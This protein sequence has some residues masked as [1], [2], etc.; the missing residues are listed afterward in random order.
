[1]TDFRGEVISSET[2]ARGRRIINS[3]SISE[4]HAVDFTDSD[5]FYKALNAKVNLS[6]VGSSKERHGVTSESLSQKWFISPEA[7]R[8]N[9]QYTTQRGIRTILHPSL[10]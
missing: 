5:N 10:S 2:I 9:L 1:M 7:A 8:R 3:L 6:K 4:D